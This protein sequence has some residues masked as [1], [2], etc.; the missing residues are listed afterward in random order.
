MC[1]GRIYEP[2]STFTSSMFYKSPPAALEASSVSLLGTYQAD[3]EADGS[4]KYTMPAKVPEYQPVKKAYHMDADFGPKR[5]PLAD[6]EFAAYADKMA[7]M[8]EASQKVVPDQVAGKDIIADRKALLDLLDFVKFE[9]LSDYLRNSSMRLNQLDIVKITKS[10]S[11]A[12]VLDT[13]YDPT[14]MFAETGKEHRSL[15]RWGKWLRERSHNGD[16][17]TAWKTLTLNSEFTDD[18]MVAIADGYG[19]FD[20]KKVQPIVGRE[21]KVIDPNQAGSSHMVVR[22]DRREG[23]TAP[24]HYRFVD[25]EL[26]GMKFL[27]RADGH[28]KEG[29]SNVELG[30]VEHFNQQDLSMID[31]YFKMLLG[32]VDKYAVGFHKCIDRHHKGMDTSDASIIEPGFVQ[33]KTFQ[34]VVGKNPKMKEVAEKRFGKLIDLLNK[35]KSNISG[36]GPWVL[37]WQYDEDTGGALHLGKYE[38]AEIP[39]EEKEEEV[40]IM[41]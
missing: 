31:V 35:V 41:A 14:K 6:E 2:I 30:L 32:K 12:L 17:W 36:D 39:E 15:V 5:P 27:V 13:V 10:P 24:K 26:G 29:D 8:S 22:G 21:T 4:T 16:Y 25:F 11:G 38:L 7:S 23:W 37:Q 40:V 28:G 34:E 20:M 3:E 9:G 19:L 18:D 33:E 1:L